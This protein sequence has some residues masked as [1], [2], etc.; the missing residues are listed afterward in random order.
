MIDIKR[1]KTETGT[2]PLNVSTMPPIPALNHNGMETQTDPPAFVA[3]TQI[4]VTAGEVFVSN[5]GLDAA[6]GD[7]K[8]VQHFCIDCCMP[9]R[10]DKMIKFRGVWYGIPCGDFRH[11]IDI[12]R[13]EKQRAFRPPRNNEPGAVPFAS[14]ADF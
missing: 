12:L 10:E 3:E 11:A 14:S 6:A 7:S 13:K 9:F 4:S 5:M 8:R 2:D 1:Y